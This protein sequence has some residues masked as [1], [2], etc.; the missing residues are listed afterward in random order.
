MLK[1]ISVGSRVGDRTDDAETRVARAFVEFHWKADTDPCI[2][3]SIQ[4]APQS[5]RHASIAGD[6]ST[7]HSPNATPLPQKMPDRIKARTPVTRRGCSFQSSLW[8]CYRRM[9][10]EPESTRRF[11][12]RTRGAGKDCQ[13]QPITAHAVHAGLI[14]AVRAK[15]GGA[16]RRLARGEFYRSKKTQSMGRSWISMSDDRCVDGQRSSM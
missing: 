5:R 8:T 10:K 3:R 9:T 2:K 7:V 4:L 15:R 16:T 1:N 14:D 6:G 11:H 13:A 12:C